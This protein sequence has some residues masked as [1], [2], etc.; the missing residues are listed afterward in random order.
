MDAEASSSAKTAIIVVGKPA[1]RG[2]VKTRLA[3]SVGDQIATDLYARFLAD[4]A[5]L[6]STVRDGSEGTVEAILAWKGDRDHAS[7]LPFERAGFEFVE[8]PEGDLG[9]CMRGLARAV[10]DHGADQVVIIG[11]DSPTL[12]PRHL[13]GAIG[14]LERGA[15]VVLGPSFDGGY[16]MIGLSEPHEAVFADIDWS[17]GAVLGQTLRRAREAQLLCE[18]TEFWYDVDTLGDLKKMRA[19]LFDFLRLRHPEVAAET[20]RFLEALPEGALEE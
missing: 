7:Y 17:T 3:D 6:T 10:F 19:H 11:T 8:Q 16:Y 13:R 20:R 18:L 14:H 9:A 1:R 15:D 12:Q 4:I 5:S 2:R